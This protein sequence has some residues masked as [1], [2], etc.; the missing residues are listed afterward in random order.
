MRIK[1]D[2]EEPPRPEQQPPR[3]EQQPPRDRNFT[4]EQL[5]SFAPQPIS[6][7]AQLEGISGLGDFA[8]A[9]EQDAEINAHKRARNESS[10]NPESQNTNEDDFDN[11]DEDVDEDGG[12]HECDLYMECVMDA[13][14]KE[15][16]FYRFFF[17]I[18]STHMLPN[19][20][21]L[22]M[23]KNNAKHTVNPEVEIKPHDLWRTVKSTEELTKLLQLYCNSS[24]TSMVDAAMQSSERNKLNPVAAENLFHCNKTFLICAC[25]DINPRQGHTHYAS[26]KTA[27]CFPLPQYVYKISSNMVSSESIFRRLLPDYQRQVSLNTYSVISTAYKRDVARAELSA[28]ITSNPVIAQE[29]CKLFGGLEMVKDGDYSGAHDHEFENY[30][31][32]QAGLYGKIRH[33]SEHF[34]QLLQNRIPTKIHYLARRYLERCFYIIVTTFVFHAYDRV[35]RGAYPGLSPAEDIIQKTIL[36]LKLYEEMDHLFTK[37]NIHET[38]HLS[39]NIRFYEIMDMIFKMKESKRLTMLVWKSSMTAFIVDFKTPAN[40]VMITSVKG[41]S[42]KSF[43]VQV[44]ISIMIQGIAQTYARITE[45]SWGGDRKQMSSQFIFLDEMSLRLL[46]AQFEDERILKHIQSNARYK[47]QHMDLV[48]K[49]DSMRQ[50][51]KTANLEVE[52]KVTFAATN[53]VPKLYDITSPAFQRRWIIESVHEGYGQD[54]DKRIL[55]SRLLEASGFRKSGDRSSLTKILRS[56]YIEQALVFDSFKLIYCGG[57]TAI[58]RQLIL[59]FF[60]ELDNFLE[61]HNYR[62]Q[63]PTD[64]DFLINHMD[65]EVVL[66]A[67]RSVFIN[68]VRNPSDPTY[69][70]CRPRIRSTDFR[71]VDRYLFVCIRHLVATLG[72]ISQKV[73]D[74]MEYDIRLALR[75][76]HSDLLKTT[77]PKFLFPSK[78]QAAYDPTSGNDGSVSIVTDSREWDPSYCSFYLNGGFQNFA[79]TL[80]RIMLENDVPLVPSIDRITHSLKDRILKERQIRAY[81]YQFYDKASQIGK[82]HERKPSPPQTEIDRQFDNTRNPAFLNVKIDEVKGQYVISQ[83]EAY[84]PSK[85]SSPDSYRPPPQPEKVNAARLESHGKTL[86]YQVHRSFLEDCGKPCKHVLGEFVMKFMSH[87]HQKE[88]VFAFGANEC[89]PDQL[90]MIHVPKSQPDAPILQTEKIEDISVERWKSAAKMNVPIAQSDMLPLKI[91]V[92]TDFD[93]WAQ[94]FRNDDLRLTTKPINP[95]I[96][97]CAKLF[98]LKINSSSTLGTGCYFMGVPLETYQYVEHLSIDDIVSK[99]SDTFHNRDRRLVP[100]DID[101]DALNLHLFRHPTALNGQGMPPDEE[102][103][104]HWDGI[105]GEPFRRITYH[106]FRDEVAKQRPQGQVAGFRQLIKATTTREQQRT[107]FRHN[108]RLYKVML[109]YHMLHDHRY[110][111]EHDLRF[112]KSLEPFLDAESAAKKKTARSSRKRKATQVEVVEDE[113][114]MPQGKIEAVDY[115]HAVS[116]KINN[117]LSVDNFTEPLD[118]LDNEPMVAVESPIVIIDE[119]DISDEMEIID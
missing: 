47:S 53:N 113:V 92:E 7:S 8:A 119:D 51:R 35:C 83:K 4:P 57:L 82:M 44:A 115:M 118:T 17:L 39:H 25:C 107:V 89:H 29:I 11:D 116:T 102:T 85:N 80:Q 31:D 88:Q 32:Y 34:F 41:G 76:Y 24:A 60:K 93:V 38:F 98:N 58:S 15:V 18:K 63:L 79:R 110:G 96:L 59:P 70:T 117:D 46:D 13:E 52:L 73:I 75:K 62:T 87:R 100:D 84:I 45:K 65:V 61:E 37:R 42:G 12:R 43:A 55:I 81:S 78:L 36:D 99:L 33:I 5:S 68:E 22:S 101:F 114:P 103:L 72:E 2:T 9:D 23:I 71:A 50:E 112:S 49:A 56:F 30:N 66:D 19:S 90:Q 10:G 40:S 104:Y 64:R 77:N 86:I 74:P 6:E 48:R 67:V 109:P 20:R 21:L 97:D 108:M 26:N 27:I 69:K 111:L 14:E 1:N 54:A 16:L 91:K 3:P 94:E 106:E 105:Y 95:K 28:G